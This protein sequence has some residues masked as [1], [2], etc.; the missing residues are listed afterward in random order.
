MITDAKCS[1]EKMDAIR[2]YGAEL[3]IAKPDENYMNME[4]DLGAQNP[5]WFC[6]NQYVAAAAPRI[7]NAHLECPR[8]ECFQPALPPAAW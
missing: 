6:V 3:R 2:C 1:K 8:L 4:L 5:S 7:G